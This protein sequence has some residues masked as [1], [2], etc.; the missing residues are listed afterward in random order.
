MGWDGFCRMSFPIYVHRHLYGIQ[1]KL[2]L[3]TFRHMLQ[4]IL[5]HWVIQILTQ[6]ITEFSNDFF[7]VCFH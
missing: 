6:I 1:V 5:T 4:E 7:T 3:W 2:A